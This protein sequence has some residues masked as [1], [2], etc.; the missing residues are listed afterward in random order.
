[1]YFTFIEKAN[2]IALMVDDLLFKKE[3]LSPLESAYFHYWTLGSRGSEF[4]YQLLALQGFLL[5]IYLPFDRRIS[6]PVY[7]NF[8]HIKCGQQQLFLEKK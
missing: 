1:M 3:H 7:K 5:S 2:V 8:S 4:S 6:R